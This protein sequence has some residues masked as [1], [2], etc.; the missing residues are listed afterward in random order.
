MK[1]TRKL[2][3]NTSSD[4]YSIDE[5]T[6]AKISAG[7]QTLAFICEGA[8]ITKPYSKFKTEDGEVR[9]WISATTCQELIDKLNE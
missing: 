3:V 9:Y 1:I 8:G 7:L 6:D 2:N 5:A 4:N